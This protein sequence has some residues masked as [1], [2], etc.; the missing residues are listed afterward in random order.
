[1]PRAGL[2]LCRP[3]RAD[4]ARSRAATRASPRRRSH[5][6]HTLL[7]DVV[8]TGHVQAGRRDNDSAIPLDIEPESRRL[9]RNPAAWMT[10]AEMLATAAGQRLHR[11]KEQP[12]DRLQLRQCVLPPWRGST[13]STTNP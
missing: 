2:R 7:P 4:R 10:E 5:P 6:G 9:A 13:S 8:A 12:V 11:A 3:L 1:R